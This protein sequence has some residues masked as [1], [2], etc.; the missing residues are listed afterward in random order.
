MFENQYIGVCTKDGREIMCGDIVESIYDCPCGEHTVRGIVEYD[1]VVACFMLDIP[2]KG[3]ALP[4]SDFR[5][6]GFVY[7]GSDAAANLGA[8]HPL[9]KSKELVEG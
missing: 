4:L 7:L 9:L 8:G 2:H 3:M 1:P 6:A 5:E